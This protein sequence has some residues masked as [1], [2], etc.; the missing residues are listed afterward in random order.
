[1][2]AVMKTKKQT[3]KMD[4]F[5]ASL[6]EGLKFS[7][8]EKAKVKVETLQIRIAAEDIKAARHVL[9]V[10]Q[11]QFARLMSVSPETVKKWEQG[12]NPIPAAVGYCAVGLKTHPDR[13]KQLLFEMVGR[14]SGARPRTVR[15]ISR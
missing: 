2:K 12:R 3:P 14:L 7:R 11:P 6:Q 8:G 4:D 10:S 9:K 1:M 15:C 13:T 5:N